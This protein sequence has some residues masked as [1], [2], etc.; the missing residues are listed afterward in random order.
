MNKR[1]DFTSRQ[2][3]IESFFSKSQLTEGNEGADKA[4]CLRRPANMALVPSAIRVQPV[5]VTPVDTNVML[6]TMERKF[7]ESIDGS[8][9]H[10]FY[11]CREKRCS[12]NE[13]AFSSSSKGET[14]R[15]FTIELLLNEKR[16]RKR[17]SLSFPVSQPQRF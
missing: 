1:K 10:S 11:H 15:H 9:F 7:P 5:T 8:G 17:L 4:A 3:G 13:P 14:V 2:P 6:K 16:M 12:L